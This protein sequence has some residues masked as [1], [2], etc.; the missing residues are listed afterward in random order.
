MLNENGHCLARRLIALV[1]SSILFAVASAEQSALGQAA[2]PSFISHTARLATD[3]PPGSSGGLY[4]IGSSGKRIG[5]CVLKNTDVYVHISGYTASVDVIQQ[6]Q[7]PFLGRIEALYAFPLPANAAADDMT[8][9]VGSRLIHG[10]VKRREEV[11]KTFENC[12]YYNDLDVNWALDQ[13]RSNTFT[14]SVPNIEPCRDITVTLHYVDLLPFDCGTYSFVFPMA[15]CL[16]PAPSANLSY[17]DLWARKERA[18][19]SKTLFNDIGP[20]VNPLF[21]PEGTRSGRDISLSVELDTAIPFKNLY[22]PF[23]QISIQPSSPTRA[24]VELARKNTISNRDFVLSWTVGSEDARGGYFAHK[25]GKSGFLSLMLVPPVRTTRQIAEP[26]E[27][28]FLVDKSGTQSGLQLDKVK[29]TM[30]CILNRHMNPHD[31]LQI[32]SFADNVDQLFDKPRELDKH[33]KYLAELYI[34]RLQAGTSTFM[35]HAIKRLCSLPADQCRP[36][37]VIFITDGYVGNDHEILGMIRKTRG[38]S[39]WFAIGT[40]NPSNRFLIDGIAREGGGQADYVVG[41]VTGVADHVCQFIESHVLSDMR[42]DFEGIKVLEVFPRRVSDVMAEQPIYIQARYSKPGHGVAH[43]HGVC[44][45]SPYDHDVSFDLPDYQLEH[46]EIAQ[47]WARTAV[48]ELV[49]SYWCATVNRTFDAELKE[50]LI[51]LALQFNIV[52]QFT[53]FDTVDEGNFIFGLPKHLERRVDV[54]DGISL[55][56]LFRRGDQAAQVLLCPDP[57]PVPPSRFAG[58]PAEEFARPYTPNEPY[59]S[60]MPEEITPISVAETPATAQPPGLWT[61]LVNWICAFFPDSNE[62]S[63]THRTQLPSGTVTSIVMSLL[64]LFV[65]SSNIAKA[66]IYVDPDAQVEMILTPGDVFASGS[67]SQHTLVNTFVA[68]ASVNSFAKLKV[69]MTLIGQLLD[70]LVASVGLVVIVSGLW[71]LR[72]KRQGCWKRVSFGIFWI[73]SVYTYCAAIVPWVIWISASH[74]LR[75][76][77]RASA[78]KTEIA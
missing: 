38:T 40:G 54:P 64:A 32:M 52:T 58:W 57:P 77:R 23:H 70:L 66:Q 26:K 15:V 7:N 13:Q 39:R 34:D 18:S 8:L 35:G 68:V 72:T 78:P 53:S 49:A 19:Q 20:K 28:I 46:S 17:G 5:N 27:I 3:N 30:H 59:F 71:R 75:R 16:G 56:E 33:T 61:S 63:E 41:A 44:D 50:G 69:A 12:Q 11:Y 31:T 47:I 65:P 2:G 21:A 1:M 14:V 67:T 60:H 43:I 22:S 42:I 62:C 36:R 24:H 55:G 37:I 45:G 51:R 10:T 4:A 48:D 73:A 74:L 6:F 9:R 29:E 76:C 25:S